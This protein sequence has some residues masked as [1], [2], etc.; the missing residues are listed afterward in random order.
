MEQL[1]EPKP[2]QNT[3]STFL[4]ILVQKKFLTTAKEGRIF[5]YSVM[6]PKKN[7]SELLVQILVENYF[8]NTPDLLLKT[9][10][11]QYNLPHSFQT[12]TD[13]KNAEV[14]IPANPVAELIA[15]LTDTR[16]KKKKTKKKKEKKKK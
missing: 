1:P 15:E 9:I 12:T 13:S 8:E 11:T 2:H 5:R 10:A 14:Q 3:I 7:Y 16:K 6:V 4:K